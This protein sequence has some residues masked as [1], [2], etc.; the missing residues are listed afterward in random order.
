MDLELL[1]GSVTAVMGPSGSGKST[2]VSVA[3]GLDTA[4][5]GSVRVAGHALDAMSPDALT[6]FRREQVGFVFQGYN[7]VPHLDV[8]S[9]IALPLVLAS[10]RPDAGW[11]AH[12]V[13]RLG[14]AGL[15]HRL[16]GELSGGQ[17][18]RVA[19]ARALVAR[20]SIVFADEPTG[21]LDARTGRQVLHLFLDVAREFGQ[22]LVVVTHDA[23]VAAATGEVVLLADGR[24]ADRMHAPSDEQVAARLLELGR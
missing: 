2:L 7:L 22:T 23:G 24:V 5:S 3:A 9:N 4:T 1:T 6:R 17:A 21:A 8:A 11:S 20:P 15:E 10:R 12:L 18:Q 19:I 14:L 13:D 16:P